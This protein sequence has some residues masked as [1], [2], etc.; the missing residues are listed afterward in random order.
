MKKT[1]LTDSHISLNAKMG[2]FAGYNMPLYY[3][4][5]VK[6]EH[7]WT[8]KNAGVFDVSH[9]GQ[10]MIE[11]EHALDFIE[12]ITPSPFQKTPVNMAKY[13]VLTNE[14]G[15]I[16]D[17][18][19]ITKLSETQFFAV[20]NAGCK[21]KDIAWIQSQLPDSVALTHFEDRALI[22]LQGPKAERIL[23]ETLSLDLIALKYMR[24]VKV[25]EL[26]I[27]RLGYTGEDGF[28]I[29]V[30]AAYAPA[31]WDRLLEH[32]LVK[33][34]G[35]AARDSL[36]LEMGYPLYGHDID[37]TTTPIEADISWIM[38]KK[39]NQSFIGA[40]KVFEHINHGTERVRAGYT[41]T[42]K[43]VAREG[44]E[45]RNLSDEKIG[46][47]TSGGYS[48]TLEQSIGMGYIDPDYNQTGTEIFIN[49]RG[50]N[51]EAVI[52]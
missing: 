12:R 31:L 30:P 52:T 41:L 40:E 26:F 39:L 2:E 51:I 14:A 36:R 9:M 38:G 20:I 34:I 19:I 43:G 17:D 32:R 4:L 44:A 45:I 27:S 49:V 22:A 15:G 25:D 18:L 33:P 37:A 5:G 6:V 3:E 7:L 35:L 42:G 16:I 29:S 48:P 24:M 10:V 47:V 23:T 28:E 11:G 1:P 13:T 8:R 50:R 21:E 46:D